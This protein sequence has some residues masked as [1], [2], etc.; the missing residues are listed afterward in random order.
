LSR[1][2]RPCN[3]SQRVCSA[4]HLPDVN[5]A[6]DDVTCILLTWCF[7]HV[8][9]CHKDAVLWMCALSLSLFCQVVAKEPQVIVASLSV[10]QQPTRQACAMLLLQACPEALSKA[11]ITKNNRHKET[12][13]QVMTIDGT[14]ACQCICRLLVTY[15]HVCAHGA[16][17]SGAR[18]ARAQ[19]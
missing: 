15:D 10:H 19:R 13:C 12:A 14:L 4:V 7:R 16:Q 11:P 6:Y 18:N 9:A 8:G 17:R 3:K 2:A 5:A 1:P